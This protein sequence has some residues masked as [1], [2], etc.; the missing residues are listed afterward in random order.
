[1]PSEWRLCSAA[2]KDAKTCRRWEA[3]ESSERQAAV[4]RGVGVLAKV[5]DAEGA[6]TP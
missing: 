1:M 4:G 6:L 3:V 2:T 5:D